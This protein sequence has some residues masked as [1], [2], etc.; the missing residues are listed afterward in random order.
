MATPVQA[1]Q[2]ITKLKYLQ[3]ELYRR[4]NAT[5][6]AGVGA[7]SPGELA[8]TSQ[9]AKHKSGQ[10]TQLI[11]TLGVDAP[12]RPAPDTFYD[13]SAGS[14]SGVGPFRNAT[15]GVTPSKAEF[16]RLAQL[17]EDFGLR[18][19]KGQLAD[20]MPDKVKLGLVL[21][22]HAVD[23]RHA[24]EIR[25]MRGGAAAKTMVNAVTTAYQTAVSPWITNAT[26]T[27]YDV[28]TGG[29]TGTETDTNSQAFVATLA[30]G[31]LYTGADR[32]TRPTD[33]EANPSQR[34]YATAPGESFDEPMTTAT[35]AIFLARFGVV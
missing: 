19:I 10:A 13:M 9:I 8:V 3:A 4:G 16:F 32:F 21:Q 26:T 34:G 14:G 6:A 11:Q 28:G 2:F 29:F 15:G 17:V 30:Y 27:I 7:F 22:A 25:T 20:L 5:F 1:L 35:C 31:V 24:A 18:L 23:G 12:V 33:T